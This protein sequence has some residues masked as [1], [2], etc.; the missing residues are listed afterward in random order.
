MVKAYPYSYSCNPMKVNLPEAT[1]LGQDSSF[2]RENVA[3]STSNKILKGKIHVRKSNLWPANKTFFSCM[4][5]WP[6]FVPWSISCGTTSS[7]PNSVTIYCWQ[8]WIWIWDCGFSFTSS[9]SNSNKSQIKENGS[10]AMFMNVFFRTRNFQNNSYDVTVRSP[11]LRCKSNV[12]H[13]YQ[14]WP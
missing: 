12:S 14:L 5:M 4:Y 1:L 2:Y 13:S 8:R 9:I 3:G 7:R 10:G 6:F 11:Y